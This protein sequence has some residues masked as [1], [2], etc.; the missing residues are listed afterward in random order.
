ME[1]LLHI[2]RK[3]IALKQPFQ[4]NFQGNSLMPQMRTSG[5]RIS[6]RNG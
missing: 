2:I 5:G 1:R 3:W 6:W 4:T